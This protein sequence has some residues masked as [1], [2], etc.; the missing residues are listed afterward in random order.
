MEFTTS[1]RQ[2]GA[3]LVQR[4]S[5]RNLFSGVFSSEEIWT[6]LSE[7]SL[8]YGTNVD[9]TLFTPDKRR[10]TFN[11]NAL[12]VFERQSQPNGNR[13]AENGHNQAGPG[14]KRKGK[15]RKKSG[16]MAADTGAAT[17]QVLSRAAVCVLYFHSVFS[18]A[19]HQYWVTVLLF[20]FC[21]RRNYRKNMRDFL[22]SLLLDCVACVYAFPGC[23]GTSC[24]NSS[25]S[26]K[27]PHVCCDV[28]GAGVGG[29][30]TWE[31]ATDGN[32]G[33]QGPCLL[34]PVCLLF[35][36]VRDFF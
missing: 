19:V 20:L 29:C 26:V 35:A 10:E 15:K 34:F 36:C 30:P 5:A 32:N 4:Q 21:F 22:P 2:Q 31:S 14:G 13:G 7:H 9:V 3:L 18:V 25:A 27:R 8:E 23:P 28:V 1:I 24:C 6:L 11:D 33:Q 12:E 16:L 17:T